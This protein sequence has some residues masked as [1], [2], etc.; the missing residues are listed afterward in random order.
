MPDSARNVVL[1]SDDP[2]W[3]HACQ[4][5]LHERGLEGVETYNCWS[6]EVAM[7]LHHG[8]AVV[9]DANIVCDT[10]SPERPGPVLFLSPRIPVVVFNA[11][12]LSEEHRAASVAHKAILLEG[13][14]AADIARLLASRLPG[15]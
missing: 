14:D 5:A 15:G 2:Q 1:V 7:K 10:V 8:G 12:D 3:V 6:A 9:I 11:A 13:N 4:A